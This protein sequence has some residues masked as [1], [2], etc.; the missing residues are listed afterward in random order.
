MK[1]AERC[2]TSNEWA[3]AN[4]NSPGPESM[5]CINVYSVLLNTHKMTGPKPT[6]REGGEIPGILVVLP[7][8][9]NHQTFKR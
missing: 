4:K 9:H 7:P 3:S 1:D 8:A 2:S 5:N 6:L